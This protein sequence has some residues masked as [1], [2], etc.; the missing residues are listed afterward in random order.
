[1]NNIISKLIIVFLTSF[2]FLINC[3][4]RLRDNPLDPKGDTD[5]RINLS[6]L[7][8]NDRIV[9]TWN[10]INMSD[11]IGFN[12][13]RKTESES[14]FKL[15][16]RELP[17]AQTIYSDLQVKLL[18]NHSYYIT[19]Q[20]QS[21]VSAPSNIVSITPGQGYNWVVDKWGYQVL[22]LTYDAQYQ[23]ARYLTD[24]TPQ[25]I[26]IDSKTNTALITMPHGN[27]MDIIDAT[28]AELFN[29]ITSSIY[30]FV[31][32]PYLVEFESTNDMFWISDSGGSVYRISAINFAVDSLESDI[33]KP[34]ELFLNLYENMVYIVD[35]NSNKIY[36]YN[37]NGNYI[38]NFSQIAGYHFKNPQKIIFDQVDDQFWFVDKS[39]N[40]YYLFTGYMGNSQISVVDSFEYF[41]E[42]SIS[43]FDNITRISVYKDDTFK[44]MQLSK[45]GIRQ[46]PLTGFNLPSHIT[47]NPY[48]GS[49][50]VTDY[51]NGRVLHY[52]GDFEILGIFTKLNAPI[53]LEVE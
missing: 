42:I 34:D 9:L 4:E 30:S 50:L 14:V 12:I 1:M 45:E 13:Y 44:I 20:G 53:R 40:S 33:L 31:N 48:D 46:L 7:S 28:S 49:L 23:I 11:L 32:K 8:Y 41:Y 51:G 47:H 16:Y 3:T 5:P 27:R 29:R 21:S 38:D 25:D 52:D 39:E 18:E 35:D 43:P 10:K 24:W 17:P 22:K 19:I 15:I 36:R 2:V 26:A 6:V 37:F